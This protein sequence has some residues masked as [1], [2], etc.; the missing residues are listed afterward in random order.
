MKMAKYL[1]TGLVMILAGCGNMQQDIDKQHAVVSQRVNNSSG[2]L[3]SKNVTSN[4]AT[5][6]RSRGAWL[7]MRALPLQA[8]STLPEIFR[9]PYVW[10]YPGRHSIT[11]IAEKITKKFGIP[12]RV[13]P[14]VFLPPS[15]FVATNNGSGSNTLQSSAPQT[16]GAPGELPA[17]PAPNA[18]LRGVQASGT[19]LINA[20]ATAAEYELN[21]EGTLAGFLDNLQARSGVSWE[22]REGVISLHRLVTK[23]FTLK[24]VPGSSEFNSSIGKGGD[25][26]TGTTSGNSTVGFS[27]TSNIK[28]EA[29]FS[30]WDSLKE[31]ITSLM[32]PAGKFAI[33]QATGNITATDTRDVIEQIS[34]LIDMENAMLTRQIAMKVE[35]LSVELNKANQYGV[36]WNA[37]FNQLS[38]NFSVKFASPTS[39]V[40]TDAASM[41]ATVLAPLS[42]T[43][44]SATQRSFGGTQAMFNA[45]HNFGKVD[46]VTTANALT[47][48]RQPVPVAITNQVSYLAEITPAP[49]G[50]S[51]TVGGTP[52]LKA[53]TVTTGF[54]LNL[55][56]TVLD[57]NNILLQFSMGMSDLTKM[58]KVSSGV[59]DLQQSIQTPEVAG[60]EFLQRVAVKAGE[61]L[62]LSGYER[63]AGQYD[64][65]TLSEGAPIGVGGSFNGTDNRRA[66]VILITPVLSEGAI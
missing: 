57:S 54:L 55:L 3:L 12:V 7:G 26:K 2:E 41:G 62:V 42:G 23:I 17:L 21:Y 20:Q 60:T 22:Y 33:S 49:S 51:G 53:G 4:V 59:G 38:N 52:G 63:A 36:D 65:R 25:T 11:S 48:N 6:Q 13:K 56:P 34:K 43:V 5:V 27:S 45:L 47:L 30:V 9:Q 29:K 66:V 37:V 16:S 24:A 1:V 19:S 15:A 40:T 14:D 8:D 32:S 39:L 61:T 44:G 64:R 35:V 18:A 31:A 50:A 58:G 10:N 28:M 46:V